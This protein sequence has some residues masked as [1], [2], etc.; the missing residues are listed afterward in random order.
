MIS[1]GVPSS[2]HTFIEWQKFPR[3]VQR[4]GCPCFTA[5]PHSLPGASAATARLRRLMC[6][7][8]INSDCSASFNVDP[9]RCVLLLC[10]VYTLNLILST[11]PLSSSTSS[12]LTAR[13]RSGQICQWEDDSV[14][15][16][17]AR[18]VGP[19]EALEDLDTRLT[20]DDLR[21]SRASF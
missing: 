19:Q 3:H 8:G 9:S 15:L 2:P 18:L 4:A 1:H 21:R 17:R 13:P 10:I 16:P 5:P 20:H 6:N 12:L 7:Y 14:I 11:S